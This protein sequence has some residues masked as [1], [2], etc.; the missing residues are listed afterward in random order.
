MK[1]P[2]L[3]Y[4]FDREEFFANHTVSEGY[5]SYE[6]DGFGEVVYDETRLV[7]LICRYIEGGCTIKKEY[8]S[9][10]EG[11]FRF[12]DRNNCKRVFDKII[13]KRG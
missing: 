3:Y 8:L 4:Q 11:F 10:V 7:E 5:F 13:E 6:D 9:R 2:V 1:K 12:H